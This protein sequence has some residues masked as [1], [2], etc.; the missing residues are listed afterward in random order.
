MNDDR[1][2]AQGTEVASGDVRLSQGGFPHP[3]TV[4]GLMRELVLRSEFGKLK[5]IM[6]YRISKRLAGEVVLH[7]GTMEVRIAEVVL[8]PKYWGYILK[9]ENLLDSG[10]KL[11]PATFRL[12][13][14][15]AIAAATWSLS[16]KPR[17]AEQKTA[18][19]H[20]SKVYVVTKAHRL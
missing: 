14:T 19:G 5:K 1:A 7:D 20:I 6:G 13:G 11:N 4:P 3:S 15:R 16:P 2:I 17:T 10:Q 8:G 18:Q 12:D 9:V